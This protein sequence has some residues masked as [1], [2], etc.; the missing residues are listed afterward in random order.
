VHETLK[1]GC[2]AGEVE[3]PID[4]GWVAAPS[5]PPGIP[6]PVTLEITNTDGAL[7]LILEV[8][9]SPWAAAPDPPLAIREGLSRLQARGWHVDQG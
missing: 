7:R 4:D 6:D 9:W 1:I 5:D 2:Y 8:F 3:V